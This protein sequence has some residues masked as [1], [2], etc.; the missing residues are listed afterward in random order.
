MMLTP[1]AAAAAAAYIITEAVSFSQVSHTQTPQ[2]DEV[3]QP[4]KKELLLGKK[5]W[6]TETVTEKD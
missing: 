2:K 4:E 6:P 1:D 5:H 3:E